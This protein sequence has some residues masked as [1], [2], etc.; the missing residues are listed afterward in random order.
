M[1][2]LTMQ[3]RMHCKIREF[4]SQ[5]FYNAQLEDAPVIRSYD[6]TTPVVC[7]LHTAIPRPL[8][9][10]SRYCPDRASDIADISHTCLPAL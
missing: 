1:H 9:L 10:T 5:H 4:P 8:P 3:Y 2:L 7:C 6:R